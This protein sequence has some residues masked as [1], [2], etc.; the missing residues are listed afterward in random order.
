MA[1]TPEPTTDSDIH[2][3]KRVCYQL[4]GLGRL[5]FE[6][7]PRNLLNLVER[8]ERDEKALR[9]IK[10]E[11]GQVCGDFELCRHE[12]CRSSYTAWAIA[13]AALRKG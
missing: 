10:D 5:S 8:I 6:L 12:A 4:V 2:D 11:Q 9:E 1:Y 7:D 13:D 3:L